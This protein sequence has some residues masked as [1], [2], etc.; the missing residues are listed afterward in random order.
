[1]SINKNELIPS[2]NLGVMI[3]NKNIVL[4]FVSANEQGKVVAYKLN[5][6][7]QIDA[8]KVTPIND[9]FYVEK[10]PDG[11]PFSEKLSH[12]ATNQTLPIFGEIKNQKSVVALMD[13]SI[14]KPDIFWYSE[15]H[16]V[17]TVETNED[18]SFKYKDILKTESKINKLE[19]KLQKSEQSAEIEMQ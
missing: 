18:K 6:F 2:K 11:G 10:D 7:N 3:E 8:S 13:L 15:D 1:M 16:G 4:C 5:N 17:G 19:Q 12:V 14:Y 9:M